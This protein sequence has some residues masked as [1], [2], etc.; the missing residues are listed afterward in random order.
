MIVAPKHTVERYWQT[1]GPRHSPPRLVRASQ[2][3]LAVD[4]GSLQ[5]HPDGVAVRRARMG[6]WQT[7]A[8]NSAA[9]IREELGYD[10]RAGSAEFD[11]NVRGAIDRGTW[12]V[13]ECG[14]ELCFYC[15]E[16][17]YSA[18]TLQLQ[19]I[20]T[21]PALRRK[22]YAARALFAICDALLDEHPTLSLYVN[23]FNAPALA[24]Y[25]ALGFKQVGEFSTLLF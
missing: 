13:G 20:W 19:G 10:P 18:H 1:V 6:E 17:P 2:P 22:G 21:P 5:K 4:R 11:A 15:S 14:G 3:L 9:M 8:R 7:V 12:W 16:G 24:L 25:A 23:D